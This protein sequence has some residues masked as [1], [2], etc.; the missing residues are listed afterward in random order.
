MRVLAQV[1]AYVDWALEFELGEPTDFEVAYAKEMVDYLISN[2]RREQAASSSDQGDLP[3]AT[4]RYKKSLEE[5]YGVANSGYD[6]T[7]TRPGKLGHKCKGPEC[8]TSVAACKR[9]L[10]KGIVSVIL[11]SK[12]GLAILAKWLKLGPVLDF[13]VASSLSNML[14]V[15]FTMASR[16]F[17]FDAS[18]NSDK[19]P[20]DNSSVDWH[21]MAGKHH[22]RSMSCVSSYSR[23]IHILILAIVVE[24]LRGLHLWILKTGH[25]VIDRSWWPPLLSF[26]WSRT[27]RL[28]M[29][30]Q[31]YSMLLAGEGS[32]LLLLFG[33]VGCRN[34]EEFRS[35]YP[36]HVWLLRRAIS[37]SSAQLHRRHKVYLDSQLGMLQMGDFRR[38][39]DDLTENFIQPFHDK[40]PC[41]TPPGGPRKVRVMLDGK[42]LQEMVAYFFSKLWRYASLHVAW[43]ALLTI[44]PLRK[45]ARCPSAICSPR[46][47]FSS[48]C[49]LEPD[50]SGSCSKQA[51]ADGSKFLS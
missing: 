1:T 42:T 50:S 44:A 14:S 22:T 45:A 16:N 47:V 7:F 39:P 21:K 28:Q 51:S 25:S 6:R 36:D 34:F 38:T 26:L 33:R 30:L 48:L 13:L 46:H 43:D 9:K 15:L 5:F 35:Q 3:S 40:F 41:C 27:S 29:I 4:A 20:Q 19:G 49:W 12:P 10:V 11:R 18:P 31:Y 8:C 2:Y 17:Q 24:P 32:R 37:V 23:H